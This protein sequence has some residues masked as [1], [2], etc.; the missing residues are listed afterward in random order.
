[1]S[2][3]GNNTG[4]EVPTE[5]IDALGGGKRP[6]VVVTVNGFS[7]RSTVGVMGGRS[8]ISFSADKRRESGIGGG[9]RITVDIEVD[10]SPREVDV[11]AELADEL[12]AAGVRA[13]FDALAPSH[14]RAHVESVSQAKTAETRDRRI[15]T[16]LAALHGG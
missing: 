4:I 16:V 2:Q 15:A 6:A 11:P 12:D 7:F 8:M 14:R 9:D 10:R 5:I 3:N 13:A 1:M